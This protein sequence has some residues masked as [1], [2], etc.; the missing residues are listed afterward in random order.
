VSG[1]RNCNANFKLATDAPLSLSH[2]NVLSLYLT[3]CS[4]NNGL[5]ACVDTPCIPCRNCLK[6]SHDD[7][8]V[9]P[10]CHDKNVSI[11]SNISVANNVEETKDYMPN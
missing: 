10:C 1:D 3:T 6:K 4:T 9:M 11:F 2:C 8:L 5:H 7:M